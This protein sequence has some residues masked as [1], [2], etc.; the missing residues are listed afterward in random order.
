MEHDDM[1]AARETAS[2]EVT[3]KI[4]ALE[5]ELSAAARRSSELESNLAEARQATERAEEAARLATQNAEQVA[6]R[7]AE[8]SGDGTPSTGGTD[9]AA[10]AELRA[11]VLE[12]QTRLEQTELRARHAYAEAENAQAELRFARER[13]DATEASADNGRL[14]SELAN[15]LERAQAAE[16]MGAALRAEL[17][18]IKKG[19]DTDAA[20]E[21]ENGFDEQEEE[22]VSLRTRLS[23][24]VESKRA[25][26]DD[27][28]HQ[29]R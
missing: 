21:T 14:R 12:L 25:T 13:G 29:W 20:P 26:G 11:E 22:G 23:R 24:A 16:Q 3:T 5:A 4:T 17:V 2:L 1:L 9:D 15:A 10:V 27:D 19:V 7:L 28:S 8:G 18:L 6:I